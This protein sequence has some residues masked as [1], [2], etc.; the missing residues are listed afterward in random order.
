TPPLGRQAEL[1]QFFT[2]Y[3]YVPPA[4]VQAYGLQIPASTA[5]RYGAEACTPPETGAFNC[6]P[7]AWWKDAE[8]RNVPSPDLAYDLRPRLGA[9]YHLRDVDC[10]DEGVGAQ[11]DAG[12]SEAQ[13]LMQ[14]GCNDPQPAD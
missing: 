10:Y 12:L 14:P 13:L 9:P 5:A 6:D 1:L 3:A 2:Y 8:G 7:T 11:R 4:L